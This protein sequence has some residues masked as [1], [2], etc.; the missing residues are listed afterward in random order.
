MDKHFSELQ[1]VMTELEVNKLAFV[2]LIWGEVGGEGGLGM[3]LW[4]GVTGL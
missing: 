4:L 3:V 2:L 1:R